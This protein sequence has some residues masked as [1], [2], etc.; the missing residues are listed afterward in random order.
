MTA[1]GDPRVP[2]STQIAE[3]SIQQLFLRIVLLYKYFLHKKC[4]VRHFRV[5]RRGTGVEACKII[6][7]FT[8]IKF[9]IR[10]LV[11]AEMPV[12]DG[13]ECNIEPCLFVLIYIIQNHLFE[14]L[15]IHTISSPRAISTNWAIICC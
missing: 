5:V 10:N 13:A 7:H 2:K 11:A 14:I 9:A 3:D 1:L 12:C 15:I 6:P 8:S 4:E